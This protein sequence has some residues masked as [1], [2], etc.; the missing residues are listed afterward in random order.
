MDKT[1]FF[2]QLTEVSFYSLVGVISSNWAGFQWGKHLDVALLLAL[3]IL[4]YPMS[5]H[6][7]QSLAYRVFT[8]LTWRKM[9]GLHITNVSGIPVLFALVCL[10]PAI[11]IGGLYCVLWCCKRG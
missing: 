10:V 4:L 2:R 8:P 9:F 6:M 3:S 1:Y 5:K 11:P 7:I